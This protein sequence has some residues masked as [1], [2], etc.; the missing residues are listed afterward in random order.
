MKYKLETTSAF[1]KSFSKLDKNTQK[2]IHGW[3]IKNL[4]S[5]ENP[6][7]KGK[8][9]SSNLKGLWRYRIGDYRLICDIQDDRLVILSLIVGHRKKIYKNL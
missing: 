2:L 4:D 1:E 9:L 3:M 8:G 5:C 7:S 6:R